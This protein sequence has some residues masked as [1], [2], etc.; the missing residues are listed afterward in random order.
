MAEKHYLVS[1]IIP[2][3]NRA[4]LLEKALLS[5]ARQSYQNW[6]II[7]IDDASSDETPSVVNRFG[8]EKII[9]LRNS[10]NKGIAYNRNKGISIAKGDFISFLDDDDEWLENKIERQLETAISL[11]RNA[12]IFCNGICQGNKKFA[13]DISLN[14]GYIE[15]KDGFFPIRESIPPP[16]SW[17][18]SREIA[19]VIGSFDESI[20]VWD[21]QD[22]LLR[23]RL[24]FPVYLLNEILVKWN[25][26]GPHLYSL[27]KKLIEGK[28]RFLEKHLPLLQKDKHYLY[29]FY[30]SMAKDCL[31]LKMREKSHAYFLKALRLRPHKVEIIPKILKTL[32]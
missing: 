26:V 4:E 24:K 3:Y 16:S 12:F 9:Y 10:V 17:F 31:K 18:F 23:V 13:Q 20:Y 14:S 5:V 2:T 32:Y 29:R 19:K 1:V 15:N 28:E 7:I 25:T 8:P 11:N 30:Y 22:Y 6:E 27:N 21:D